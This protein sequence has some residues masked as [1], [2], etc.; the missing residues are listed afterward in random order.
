MY[1]QLDYRRKCLPGR[2]QHA[3]EELPESLDGTYERTLREIDDKNWEFSRRLLL[4]VAVVSRPL[5]VEELAQFLAFGFKTEPIPKF[6]EDWRLDDPLEAGLSTCSTLLSPV[7][8]NDSSVIQFSHFS[9][10]FFT[11]KC[12]NCYPIFAFLGE[13]VPGLGPLCRKM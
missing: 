4:C 1:F 6:W 3:L 5:R 10:N 11:E 12:E 13:G 9:K 8:V 7:N 2:I